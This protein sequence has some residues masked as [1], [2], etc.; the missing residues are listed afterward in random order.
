MEVLSLPLVAP[1]TLI[2]QL[3]SRRAGMFLRLDHAFDQ[4]PPSQRGL[5]FGDK[6][7]K[8]SEEILDCSDRPEWFQPMVGSADQRSGDAVV[9][10]TELPLAESESLDNLGL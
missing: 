3:N 10:R 1:T 2:Q 9:R 8:W 5:Y 6:K 4:L 7:P